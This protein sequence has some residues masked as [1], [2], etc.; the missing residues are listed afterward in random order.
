MAESAK[1]TNPHNTEAV[2]SYTYYH[3]LNF[4]TKQYT[5]VARHR[6]LSEAQSYNATILIQ[7]IF[8]TP[9]RWKIENQVLYDVNIPR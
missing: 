6:E 4:H 5:S 7:H 8:T 3:W 9:T 2:V 1:H